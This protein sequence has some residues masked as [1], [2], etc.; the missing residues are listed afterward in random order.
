VSGSDS[1]AGP[2]PEGS[3]RRG[4]AR[5]ALLDT[6]IMAAMKGLSYYEWILIADQSA[7]D[8]V[9]QKDINVIFRMVWVDGFRWSR[10]D[11]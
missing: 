7:I 6:A 9:S 2:A 8:A 3:E 11:T 1:A 5:Y 10:S 4:D